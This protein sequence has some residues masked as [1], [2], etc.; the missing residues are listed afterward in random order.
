MNTRERLSTIHKNLVVSYDEGELLGHVTNVYFDKSSCSIKGLTIAPKLV[1]AEWELFVSFEDIHRLG[2]SVVIVSSQKDLKK[3]PQKLEGSSLKDLKKIKVVTED[4]KHLGGLLDVNVF[5][6]SGVVSHIILYDSKKLKIDVEK[7]KISIGPD[8]IIVP[9]V[10]KSR[11]EVLKE[12]EKSGFVANAERATRSVTESIRSAIFSV[13][14]NKAKG[15]EKAP[16]KKTP[17]LAAKKNGQS[18]PDS[19]AKTSPSPAKKAAVKK[20]AKKTTTTTSKKRPS[21]KAVKK[22][23]KK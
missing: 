13:S 21:K 19:N 11:V 20:A 14:Q 7:D 15:T 2:T 9:S 23:G 5:A 8:M 1:K 4:G 18:K 22:T 12:S 6:K 17:G 10:Y 16:L 3:T